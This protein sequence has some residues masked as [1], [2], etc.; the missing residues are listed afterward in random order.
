V[1]EW[2]RAAGRQR[3]LTWGVPVSLAMSWF[4]PAETPAINTPFM[5]LYTLDDAMVKPMPVAPRG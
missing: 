4:D 2:A 1:P 5:V 3:Q